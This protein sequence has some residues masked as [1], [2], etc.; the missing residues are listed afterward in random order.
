MALRFLNDPNPAAQFYGDKRLF[1]S[2]DTPTAPDPQQT[3]AA[4]TVAN[5]DTAYWNA[6]LNNVNQIT[7]YG[8]LT[9][10]ENPYVSDFDQTAYDKALVDYQNTGVWSDIRGGTSAA[11][12]LSQKNTFDRNYG[13]APSFT[14]TIE[15]NP[16]SQKLLDSQMRSQNA[17]ATLG[18]G[19]LGRISNAVSTPY[20][21]AGLGDAPTTSDIN[22]LS[23]Q[24]Q[25]AIMARLNPQ[26]GY[27]E[28]ALRTRLINQGIGQGSEAYNRE[29]DRF[30]QSKNDAR[31]QAVLQGANYGGTLQN[32]SLANRNQA[33]QE[34]NAQRNAPLN[35][36]TAMTSGSQI[37][38][39]SF[40]STNTQGAAPVDYAGLVNQNYQNQTGQANASTANKNATTGSA[41]SL[42]GTA[43]MIF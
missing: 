23:Q 31:T 16:E 3:A 34:Y 20:S 39:P 8:N 17:L 26:F 28:E 40:Q 11:D 6:S 18:E 43:A 9:Y 38:N 7:P 12:P 35:E 10:K 2:P 41:F 1:K 15:L 24:G 13:K 37:Q 30:N 29:M 21:Y 22:Q 33:I 25:D 42:I 4:Q 14:S 36:Y 5:K 19:Q 32:Q 27:D